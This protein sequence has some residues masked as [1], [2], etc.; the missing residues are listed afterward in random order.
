MQALIIS[1]VLEHSTVATR[2]RAVELFLA[3]R[4]VLLEEPPHL[5]PLVAPVVRA[6]G[7]II[8][9]PRILHVLCHLARGVEGHR[10]LLAGRPVLVVPA[11]PAADAAIAA[12]P[13]ERSVR[14]RTHRT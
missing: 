9:A 8:P 4:D 3:K 13:E 10:A 12:K 2:L 1:R 14:Q 6:L 7:I 11:H 5:P